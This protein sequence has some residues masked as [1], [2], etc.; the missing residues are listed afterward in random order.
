MRP[1]KRKWPED[2]TEKV[3]LFH[4][5]SHSAGVYRMRGWSGTRSGEDKMNFTSAFTEIKKGTT[6]FLNVLVFQQNCFAYA[7]TCSRVTSW[8]NCTENRIRVERRCQRFCLCFEGLHEVSA[9]IGF[10]RR[11]EKGFRPHEWVI[12]CIE[13]VWRKEI[14]KKN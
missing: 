2:R 3:C 6:I 8:T 11:S 12:L 10:S 1:Y 7:F 5:G 9:D 13:A 4:L 14:T